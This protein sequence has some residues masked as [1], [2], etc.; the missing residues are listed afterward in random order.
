MDLEFWKTL[1]TLFAVCSA[2]LAPTIWFVRWQANKSEESLNKM[3]ENNESHSRETRD[4]LRDFRDHFDR[5]IGEVYSSI[6]V[7]NKELRDQIN[8][9]IGNV[10]TMVG[11]LE[12][13]VDRTIDKNHEIEKNMMR[14]ENDIQK[15]FVSRD[16]FDTVI[17][18]H[19]KIKDV[20]EAE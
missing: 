19:N 4:E 20:E 8:S 18:L 15:N 12:T 16:H 11:D 5:R 1:A 9:E 7:K 2:I 6:E 17:R 13:K 10:K 14:M 3:S